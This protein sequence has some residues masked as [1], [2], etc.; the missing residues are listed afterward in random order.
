MGLPPNLTRKLSQATCD[1]T[2][3]NRL[4]LCLCRSFREVERLLRCGKKEEK[5]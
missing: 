4:A 2:K 3:L 1:K 5:C